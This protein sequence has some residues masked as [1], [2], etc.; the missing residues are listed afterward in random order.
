V[1]VT[2]DSLGAGQPYLLNVDG[3]L[4]DYCQF[5][6]A[7]SRKPQGLPDATLPPAAEPRT[8]KVVTLRWS[9]PDSLG[10]V[11][12]FRVWRREAAAFHT[13]ARAA[14]P[15]I[16]STF[17]TTAAGYSWTDTLSTPG[18][19][20]YQV[21]TEATDGTPPALVQQQWYSYSQ[22]MPAKP[23]PH[24]NGQRQAQF[25]QREWEKRARQLRRRR[26]SS[27]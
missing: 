13:T 2:L 20:L 15:V 16:R 21:T 4:R 26:A 8:S 24:S 9:L 11:Q 14:V 5:S 25:E 3:Y 22:L 6:L 19:Y 23:Q 18:R 1:F 10:A 12:Q 7:V 27:Q 17:G